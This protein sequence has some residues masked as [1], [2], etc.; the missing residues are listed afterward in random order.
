M[1]ETGA[2]YDLCYLHSLTTEELVDM[3]NDSPCWDDDLN[4]ELCDRAGI[5]EEWDAADA[6]DAEEIVYKA[7]DILGVEI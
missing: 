2:H 7:A 3:I 5:V 1:M 6:D 4:R